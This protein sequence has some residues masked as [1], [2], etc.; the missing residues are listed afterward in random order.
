MGW[1]K[2]NL[3]FVI[4]GVVAV[5]SLGAAGYYIYT[6]WDANSAATTKLNE[7]YD[8]LSTLQQKTPS[9]GNDKVDNTKIAN[10]QERQL[11]E[12][13]ASAS[14]TFKPVDPIPSSAPTIA[15]F[16]GALQKTVD[17]LQH[18]A[19]NVGVVLSPKYEFS[20]A[21]EK[22]KFDL[23]ATYLPQL[24]QQLG[25]VKAI[26]GIMFAA[27]VNNL[28]FIQRVRITEQDATAQTDYLD[29]HPITN[30]LAVITPYVITFRC[31]TPELARVISL[32][33]TSPNAF[34][35][36]SVNVQPYSS[37]TATP[38]GGMPGGMPG[39]PE[40]GMGMP[41]GMGPGGYPGMPAQPTATA[42]AGR[43]GLQTVLKEQLLRVTL[44]VELVKLQHKS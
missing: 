23:N 22:D 28:D 20:F 42:A 2:R 25:E 36:K 14:A 32:F 29:E 21:A 12:W 4:I 5:A 30:N 11:L 35:I 18:D 10:E 8:T 33:A 16:L 41:P 40:A 43:G 15:T 6:S 31:F 19:N 24:A 26:A 39:G 27:R 17:Q 9:P 1:I 38:G 13:I 34:I 7:T 3:L 37:A 44:Q